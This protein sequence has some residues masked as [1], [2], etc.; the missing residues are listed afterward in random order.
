MSITELAYDCNGITVNILPS[1]YLLL[2]RKMNIIELTYDD[3]LTSKFL[4]CVN[5]QTSSLAVLI[6]VVSV[7]KL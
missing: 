1:P 2:E 7:V 3:D 4:K 6:S 5:I